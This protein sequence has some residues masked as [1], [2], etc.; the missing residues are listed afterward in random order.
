MPIEPVLWHFISVLRLQFIDLIGMGSYG[1]CFKVEHTPTKKI[2]AMKVMEKFM[3]KKKGIVNY[4]NQE[5]AILEQMDFPFI[6]KLRWAF[7]TKSYLCL[8]FDYYK[9]KDL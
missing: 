6:I 5:R 2:Y 4:A 3:Y 1:M 9:N 8:V 7:Q